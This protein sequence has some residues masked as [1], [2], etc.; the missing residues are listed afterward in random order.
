M[1][2]KLHEVTTLT[3]RLLFVAAVA[4]VLFLVGRILFGVAVNIKEQFFPTPAP[5]PTVLF[6][7]LPKIAFPKNVWTGKTDKLSFSID[8][9]EGSL[10]QFPDQAKVYKPGFPKPSLLSL[11][12]ARKT[13]A[14]LGFSEN[15]KALSQTRY[16]WEDP[17]EEGRVINF[18]IVSGNFDMT[19][20]FYSD[21]NVLLARSLPNRTEAVT[22]VTE[23]LSRI[24]LLP[25]DLDLKTASV[26]FFTIEG[27]SLIETTSLAKATIVRVDLPRKPIEGVP[28]VHE[29]PNR[30]P[31]NM[32][33]ASDGAESKI[34]EAHFFYQA[35]SVSENATYPIKTADEA[36][37][38][39]KKGGGYVA[40]IASNVRE[41]GNISIQKVTIAYYV[42]GESQEFFM[43]IF[44]F[45]GNN[46]F[47]AY[48]SATHDSWISGMEEQT[49]KKKMPSQ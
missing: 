30:S 25:S 45:E 41:R 16:Q 4:F 24:D 29:S 18:D 21:E 32:L 34:V 27:T 48:I 26:S 23:F 13:V 15:E 5:T 46:N 20:N 33:I 37:E 35:I 22:L 1:A 10:P 44:V 43:P 31:I 14:L 17:Q 6:G 39:L 38:E 42:E 2:T 3:R 7:S 28:L 9:I 40:R 49:D 19:S 8:T 36:F 47:I 12:Q 11:E